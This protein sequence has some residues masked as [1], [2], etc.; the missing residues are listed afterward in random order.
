[1]TGLAEPVGTPFY[2]YSAAAVSRSYAEWREA[3]A[4]VGFGDGRHRTCF[5]V[6]A[7][8]VLALLRHLAASGSGFDVVS[9][10]ELHRV[11]AACGGAAGVVFSGPGTHPAITTGPRRTKFGLA[12]EEI[13][14]LLSTDALSECLEVRAVAVHIGSQ[15]TDLEPLAEWSGGLITEPGRVIAGPAGCRVTRVSSVRRREPR[16][17][18]V[19]DAGGTG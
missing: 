15:V 17:L 4:A 1:M 2:C 19:R 13:E 3:F 18:L 9:D 6:K 7:N 11:M 12:P 8:G 16:G 14:E 10:G 5:A